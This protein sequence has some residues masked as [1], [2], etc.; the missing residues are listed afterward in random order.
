MDAL[1]IFAV[2]RCTWGTQG[3]RNTVTAAN[4]YLS[5]PWCLPHR[6]MLLPE[7]ARPS[8]S[9]TAVMVKHFVFHRQEV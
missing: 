1:P 8:G 7:V 4:G 3:P 6:L 2:V 5:K 9:D